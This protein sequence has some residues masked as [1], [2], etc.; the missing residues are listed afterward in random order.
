L[1]EMFGCRH[2]HR[3]AVSWLT[4]GLGRKKGGDIGSGQ[5]RRVA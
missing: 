5:N 2:D 1:P 3:V 4:A